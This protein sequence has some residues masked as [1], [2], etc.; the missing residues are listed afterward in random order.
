MPDFN[1]ISSTFS[2]IYDKNVWGEGSGASGPIETR[3]YMEMLAAF[4]RNNEITSVVDVGCGDWKFS[5]EMDW[6]GIRY[7]GFDVVES[8]I[9]ANRQIGRAHV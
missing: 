3:P 1:A 2:E 5:R 7:R 4:L 6:T 9:E 8:V